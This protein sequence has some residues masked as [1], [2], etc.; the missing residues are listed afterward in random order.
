M[1]KLLVMVGTALLLSACA[2]TPEDEE[3][4]MYRNPQGGWN[5]DVNILELQPTALTSAFK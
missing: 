5:D 3:M 1:K 4:S 2:S